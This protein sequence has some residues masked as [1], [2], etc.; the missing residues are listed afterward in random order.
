MHLVVLSACRTAGGALVHGEGVQGLT[1][2]FLEAGAR[3]VAVTHWEVGDRRIVPLM[4]AFYRELATGATAG[5]ALRRARLEL[6]R[7][8]ASPAIWAGV[9][10]VGDTEVRPL[11][12]HP[13]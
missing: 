1:A 11:A 8:G 4:N 3:A 5:A 9:D 6:A 7:S 12:G 2:P 10:L 13:R